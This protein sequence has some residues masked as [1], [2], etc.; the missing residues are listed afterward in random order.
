MSLDGRPSKYDVEF[1]QKMI[2]FFNLKPT[3]M[4]LESETSE[5]IEIGENSIP[6]EKVKTTNKG[7]G[8]DFPTFTAF[9]MK[10]GVTDTT[11]ARWSKE[12]PEFCAARELCKKLQ[13]NIWI[14]NGLH[15][16]YNSQFAIFLGKNV[17]N[18]KDKQEIDNIHTIN[19]MPAIK[20]G[21]KPFNFDIGENKE[22]DVE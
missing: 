7:G 13:E 11:L 8:V 4:R 1:C 2:E 5:S 10:I 18:Y 19:L 17:F 6:A 15:G 21:G 3:Q 12:F 16:N 20:I 9:A 22:M 14:I